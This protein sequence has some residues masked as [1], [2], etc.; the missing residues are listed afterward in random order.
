VAN[1]LDVGL[2]EFYQ[3]DTFRDLLNDAKSVA[4]EKGIYVTMPELD[5]PK[6]FRFCGYPWDDFYITWDGFLVPCCAKPFPKEKHCGN[7]FD[8]GLM[9]AINAP[10]FIRFRELSNRDET[11]DFCQRCHK[12]I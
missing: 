3:T 6:G 4:R 7:V 10:D 2:Y 5:Q 11:P 9:N 1:N 8:T 12:V